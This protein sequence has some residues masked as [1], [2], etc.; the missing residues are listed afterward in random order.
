ML[1]EC[2]PPRVH[3]H[4]RRP[5]NREEV[6]VQD[7]IHD[8]D[9]VKV[10]L[11]REIE[12]SP[13]MEREGRTVLESGSDVVWFTFPGVWHDIGRFHRADGT[14]TGLYANVLTPVE[15]RSASTWHTTDL[16]LDVWW[17]PGG[18]PTLLDRD[19]LEEAVDRG[20]V[21]HATADRAEAEAREILHGAR[22]GSWPPPIVSAWT[23]ER[24]RSRVP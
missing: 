8:R 16:F 17:P 21:D 24:A 10:T 14:F 22:S 13:P 3:I 23:R 1:E 11:A 4:Y 19:Q 9:D 20:W 6:F 15:F 18:S 5:P 7:L 2:P 12:F